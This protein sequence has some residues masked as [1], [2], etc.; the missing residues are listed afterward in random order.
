M[1]R[2]LLSFGNECLPKEAKKYGGCFWIKQKMA[3]V[4]FL[5]RSP[6]LIIRRNGGETVQH[7]VF[8]QQPII[9]GKFSFYFLLILNTFVSRE[10][11]YRKQN[12]YHYAFKTQIGDRILLY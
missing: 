6:K 4:I 9:N 7:L 8:T 3:Q 10:L 2:L 12:K 11:P 1:Y 5:Q